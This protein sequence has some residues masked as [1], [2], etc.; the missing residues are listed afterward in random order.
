MASKKKKQKEKKLQLLKQTNTRTELRLIDGQFVKEYHHGMVHWERAILGREERAFEAVSQLK[1]L[2][3]GLIADEDLAKLKDTSISLAQLALYYD[4]G[5]SGARIEF[6]M[7]ALPEMI[8]R[9]IPIAGLLRPSHYS[10]F[11]DE[12]FGMARWLKNLGVD[13][14]RWDETGL[15]DLHQRIRNPESFKKMV[16][17]D[18]LFGFDSIEEFLE[19]TDRINQLRWPTVPIISFSDRGRNFSKYPAK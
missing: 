16:E 13:T 11:K 12:F 2:E 3:P 8:L 4:H 1:P 19:V 14:G 10:I 9:I 18:N 17:E 7:E 15:I 6:Y 5:K